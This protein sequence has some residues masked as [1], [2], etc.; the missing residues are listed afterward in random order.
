MLILSR[1]VG[2]S[3]ILNDDIV[4]T[5]TAVDRGRVQI[6]IRAPGYVPIYRQEIVARMVAEGQIEPLACLDQRQNAEV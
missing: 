3:I 6:G 5:V 2:E 4:V 1:K